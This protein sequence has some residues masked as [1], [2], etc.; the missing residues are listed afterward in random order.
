MFEANNLIIKIK[1]SDDYGN[2]PLPK[3][4]LPRPSAVL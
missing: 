1:V 4:Q 2:L 3:C